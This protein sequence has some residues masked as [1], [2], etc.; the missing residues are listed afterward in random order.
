MRNAQDT[1][2]SPAAPLATADQMRTVTKQVVAQALK[3]ERMLTRMFA[4]RRLTVPSS[5]LF[6]CHATRS[7]VVSLPTWVAAVAT[8]GLLP[9]LASSCCTFFPDDPRFGCRVEREYVPPPPPS[10]QPV[11]ETYVDWKPMDIPS[12]EVKC[13]QE[14]VRKA[15]I[16]FSLR[17]YDYRTC[18]SNPLFEGVIRTGTGNEIH[19][20]LLPEQGANYFLVEYSVANGTGH[21]ITPGWPAE[22]LGMIL[23]QDWHLASLRPSQLFSVVWPSNALLVPRASCP[24]KDRRCYDVDEIRDWTRLPS[25]ERG[26]FDLSPESYVLPGMTRNFVRVFQVPKEWSASPGTYKFDLTL[27]EMT[28]S[29]DPSGEPT[30]KMQFGVSCTATTYFSRIAV[31]TKKQRQVYKKS[32]S[33]RTPEERQVEAPDTAE[34]AQPAVGEWDL[35]DKSLLV[36]CKNGLSLA[37]GRKVTLT[38]STGE[39]VQGTLEG[40]WGLNLTVK[41]TQNTKVTCSL[42]DLTHVR[43]E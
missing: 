32:G 14:P 9:L 12:V 20:C 23:A 35:K 19:V 26:T 27:Y 24:V 18:L 36:E 10:P 39:V 13:S 31:A 41:T 25:G 40:I 43:V 11:T 37:V 2:R 4:G 15:D 16:Q 42:M 1:V 17:A 5:G 3:E 6:R 7:R 28:V 22:G 29:S 30:V 34:T 33:T 38:R 21:V 8:L